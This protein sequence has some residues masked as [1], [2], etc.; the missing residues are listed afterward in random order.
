MTTIL[1]LITGLEIGGAERMLTHLVTQTDRRYFTS[2]V[3]SLTDGGAMEP[4]LADAGVALETLQIQRGIVDP[5][6]LT[7][8]VRVL[9]KRRPDVLQTWLYHADLLGLF[10]RQ[11]RDP[12][13]L[14]WNIRCSESVGSGAVRFLLSRC[15][16]V[17]DGVVVNSLAGQRFHQRLGYRPRRWVHIPNGFDTRALRPD[18]AARSR[19]RAELD[20]D[21]AA[22]VI[23]LAARYHPMKDHANFLAAAARLTEKR[24]ELRFLLIGSGMDLSNRPLVKAICEH[25]LMSRVRL[26]GAREDMGALYPGLDI[27]TLSSAFGEGFPNVLGEAMCCGVPCVATC[28]GDSAEILG[29]TGVV[30]P[31]RDPAALADGWDRLIS[32]DV[33]ER[34]AIGAKARER[35]VRNFDLP[36]IVKR[37]EAL[38]DEVAAQRQRDRSPQSD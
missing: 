2:V 35:I 10:V 19:L 13:S 21:E 12:P 33:D 4:I 27:A 11:L 31:P 24:P 36:V 29:P 23:G 15:S 25:G 14:L 8:L 32:L 37:Y 3:V 22:I 6:G 17:P 20:L 18:P 34:R 30:V 9:R 1:H 5:R 26:L 7:R 38:Y 16:A 28:S